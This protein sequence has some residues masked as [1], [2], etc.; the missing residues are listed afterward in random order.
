MLTPSRLRPQRS[1]AVP[2][3]ELNTSK[4]VHAFPGFSGIAEDPKPFSPNPFVIKA[5]GHKMKM[6]SGTQPL[7]PRVRDENDVTIASETHSSPTRLGN[8]N[9]RF[10]AINRPRTRQGP[11]PHMYKPAPGLVHN[12]TVSAAAVEP[13]PMAINAQGSLTSLPNGSAQPTLNLPHGTNLTDL[14]SGVVRHPPP[15]TAQPTIR[16]RTSRF[17]SAARSETATEP[18]SNEIPVPADERHLLGSIDLLQNRVAE[19]E[20]QNKALTSRRRSDS[21]VS[22]A[23]DA[24]NDSKGQTAAHHRVATENI[25]KSS[26]CSSVGQRLLIMK[27]S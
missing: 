11:Q 5:N 1:P 12:A 9:T 25:R 16:P 23:D 6:A 21:A 20:T 24:S 10:G 22:V 18:K 19:L 4:L 26:G 7:Q 14:F 8:R 13:K 15:C 2:E 3:T 17:A 27:R